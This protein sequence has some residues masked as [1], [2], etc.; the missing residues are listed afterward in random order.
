MRVYVCNQNAVASGSVLRKLF[1]LLSLSL[2]MRMTMTIIS[3][4]IA[5]SLDVMLS[6]SCARRKAAMEFLY[7]FYQNSVFADAATKFGL[8]MLP[9]EVMEFYSKFI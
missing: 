5:T 9:G 1:D 8:S 7:L 4:D 3:V 6:G 2:T